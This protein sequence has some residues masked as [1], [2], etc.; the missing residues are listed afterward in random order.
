M[1]AGLPPIVYRSCPAVGELVIDHV[2]GI[3]C[4]DGVDGLASALKELM[5][6]RQERIQLGNTARKGMKQY[7][8]SKIFDRWEQVLQTAAKRGIQN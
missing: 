1:S 7:A 6:N 2:N 8:P 3:R 4:D 5:D